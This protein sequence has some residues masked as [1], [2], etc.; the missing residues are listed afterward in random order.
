MAIPNE[1]RQSYSAY[2]VEDGE[3]KCNSF[4]EI[5]LDDQVKRVPRKDS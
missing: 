2:E 3:E 4:L 5:Y 1:W